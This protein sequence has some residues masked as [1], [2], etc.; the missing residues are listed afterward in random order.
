M[1]GGN[2]SARVGW[3]AVRL[4]GGVD[5]VLPIG[6]LRGEGHADQLA[7]PCIVEQ[8]FQAGDRIVRYGGL[9]QDQSQYRPFYPA[10]FFAV[11]RLSVTCRCP[12]PRR[13]HAP[14]SLLLG[15]W[16]ENAS[17]SIAVTSA[18]TLRCSSGNA[19]N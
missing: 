3:I 7:A 19:S 12:A 4:S 5:D 2:H 17:T 16:F 10:F 9:A 14:C 6:V 18:R 15:G 11:V 8:F 13:F 1:Q